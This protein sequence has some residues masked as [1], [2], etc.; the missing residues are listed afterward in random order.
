MIHEDDKGGTLSQ[1][2]S[3]YVCVDDG[4]SNNITTVNADQCLFSSQVV[5]FSED[6]ATSPL[7]PSSDTATSSE[8]ASWSDLCELPA[9]WHCTYD[10]DPGMLVTN[11]L[12]TG[13]GCDECFLS[14]DWRFPPDFSISCLSD[15]EYFKCGDLGPG[16]HDPL[17]PVPMPG[18]DQLGPSG[19]G[20]I[21]PPCWSIN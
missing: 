2:V 12:Q 13:E 5:Q 1:V 6:S 14:A 15:H 10:T 11:E 4:H 8:F 3:K 19:A 9:A 7:S 18:Y 17:F 21:L 16:V 20:T